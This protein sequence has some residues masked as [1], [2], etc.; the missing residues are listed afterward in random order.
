MTALWIRG[1]WLKKFAILNNGKLLTEEEFTNLFKSL[2]VQLEIK[3]CINLKRTKKDWLKEF[4]KNL[5][6]TISPLLELAE[7]DSETPSEIF[8]KID[9]EDFEFPI[10]RAIQ[11]AK[12]NTEEQITEKIKNSFLKVF[13]L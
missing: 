6:S 3:N 7:L 1:C 5:Y 2:K 8:D 4:S 10:E 11:F 9:N 12:N 13:E